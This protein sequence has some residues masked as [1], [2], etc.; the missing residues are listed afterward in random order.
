MVFQDSALF[1][2]LTVAGNVGFGLSSLAPLERRGRVGDWLERLGVSALRTRR[3]DSLSG[4]ERQ[5]VAL[6]RALAPEPELLL[7]DEPFSSVDR[8]VR[9][10]LIRALGPLLKEAG[11]TTIL[12]THDARDALE[13]A[14][15]MLLLAGGIVV[16]FGAVADVMAAPGSE[17]ATHFLAC[18]LGQ[19][20]TKRASE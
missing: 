8:L 13:L 1:P 15:D 20:A 18:G 3:V 19:V 5:R 9:H 12:V 16:R 17:W 2:H 6:A 7:L 4:G 14:T 10:E 11:T